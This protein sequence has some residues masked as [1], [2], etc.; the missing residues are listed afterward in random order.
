MRRILRA[1]TAV[2]AVLALLTSCGD[3]DPPDQ[4]SETDPVTIDITFEGDTVDPSGER[5]EVEVGQ[6]I[7]LVVKADAGGEIHVHSTPEQEFEYGEG[8]TTLP[9]TID[10]PGL[11]DVESHD[12]EQVIVQL[13]VQ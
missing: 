1:S 6:Q 8:T 4:G 10:K 3:E 7:E 11:V 5:V 13:E 2:V 12:L 9:L